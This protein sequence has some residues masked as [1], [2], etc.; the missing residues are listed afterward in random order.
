[1]VIFC[2]FLLLKMC[3]DTYFIVF[4]WIS[5]KICPTKGPPKNDNIHISQNTGWKKKRF[6][7]TLLLTKN[8]CFLGCLFWNRKHACWTKNIAKHEDKTKMRKRDFKDK[9][10]QKTPQND[11]RLMKKTL[12]LNVLML[13]LPW[14][15]GKKKQKE[16]KRQNEATKRKQKKNKEEKE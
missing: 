7:A 3:W 9:T 10:R 13:F 4:F 14:N 6:V 11:K 5:T 12:L 16:R 8:M 15:K 1:M 2:L